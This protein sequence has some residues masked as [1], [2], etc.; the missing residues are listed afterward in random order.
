MHAFPRRRAAYPIFAMLSACLCAATFANDPASASA[1]SSSDPVQFN[2]DIRPILS[3]HCYTCHGPDKANRKTQMRFDTEE[4]AFTPLASGA[5]AI[6]RGDT[7][8]SVMLQR[9]T[10]DNKA[11]RMPPAYLGYSKLS[12]HDIDLVRRWIAE[13]APWQKHWSFIPPVRP[14]LPAVHNTSWPKNAIDN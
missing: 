6:V 1:G 11:I 2:R 7:S 5:F 13:G 8:K 3:E 9:I 14:P 10:S 4:G 12:E